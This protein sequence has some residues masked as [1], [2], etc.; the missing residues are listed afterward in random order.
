MQ[1]DFSD[2]TVNPTVMVVAAAVVL[3]VVIGRILLVVSHKRR[4]VRL[5]HPFGREYDLAVL[6]KGSERRGER[7]LTDRAAETKK[8]RL[9]ELGSARR[10][11]FLAE[12][13]AVQSRFLDHPRGALVE[14]D[15]LVSSLMAARGYPKSLFEPSAE[16]MNV[17][18]PWMIDDYR[19]A[20][21]IVVRSGR[22][23]A[24]TED[25]RTAMIQYRSLFDELVQEMP[26]ARQRV[27]VRVQAI[28]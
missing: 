16:F 17:D 2:P 4:T 20:H 8:R 23:E 25:L 28:S 5:K 14:A 18:H 12:W 9:R 15:E 3:A 21:A 7:N 24:A 22:G 6:E 10:E 1:S 26:A 19:A 11:R 27:P 13:V